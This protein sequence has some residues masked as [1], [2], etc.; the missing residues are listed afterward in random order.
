MLVSPDG[1]DG[2]IVSHQDA[3]LCCTLL[4]AGQRLNHLLAGD[5]RAYVHVA[6]GKA[7]VNGVAL[8]SGDAMTI[9]SRMLNC[10]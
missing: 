1:Q 9:E 8:S 6:D 5:R 3:L 2:Y 10:V 7:N 4:E